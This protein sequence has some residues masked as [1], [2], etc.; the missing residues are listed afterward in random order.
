MSQSEWWNPLG[1]TQSA[2]SRYES[3]RGIPKP[4]QLLY[5][6]AYGTPSEANQLIAKLRANSKPLRD[7]AA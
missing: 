3:G 1:L 2:S 7:L 5:T 4:V 6:I